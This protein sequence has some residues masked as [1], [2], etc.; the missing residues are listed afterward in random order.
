MKRDRTMVIVAFIGGV[1]LPFVVL[2]I[3]VA[4]GWLH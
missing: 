1:L 4:A 3:L 2:M